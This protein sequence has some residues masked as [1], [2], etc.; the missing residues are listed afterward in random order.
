MG[1]TVDPQHASIDSLIDWLRKQRRRD[2]D[3]PLS[4][5]LA[6]QK[7][8]EQKFDEQRIVDIACIDLMERRRMGYAVTVESYVKDF[9]CILDQ[10]NVLDLIDAEICVTSELGEDPQ[11]EDYVSRF[12]QLADQVI[13]LVRLDAAAEFNL[14]AAIVDVS[15]MAQR[16]SETGRGEVIATSVDQAASAQSA[17]FS[18][19]ALPSDAAT[20]NAVGAFRNPIDVPEW[21]VGEQCVAS[22]SGRWLIRGRDSVRGINLALKVTKLPP[23]LTKIQSEQIL[24]ACE[25]AAKVCNPSWVLPSVAAIQ[26]RHLGVIRPWIFARPWQQL[27]LTEDHRSQL[28][29][30]ASVAFAVAS[31]HQVGATHGGI[32]VGNLMVDHEG[33]MQILDAAASRVALERWLSPTTGHSDFEQIASL[34]ERQRIDVRDLIKLVASA[35][36]DWDQHWASDL[37][38][39]LRCIASRRPEDACAMIGEELVQHADSVNPTIGKTGRHRQRSWRIR[40]ARWLT[41]SV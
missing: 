37:V 33:K 17:D 13:E 30:L 22:G 28:R 7:F 25:M 4:S 20:A 39:D 40:L 35:S 29:N 8:A 12:P 31:G 18:I 10:S 41:N 2:P 21:F 9:S 24:D 16:V 38:S 5:L 15:D 6:D 27:R 23:R 1:G 36:V 19:E 26:E 34:D 3:S 14:T 32:H 11:I